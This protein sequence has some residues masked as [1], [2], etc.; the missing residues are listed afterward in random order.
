[1]IASACIAGPFHPSAFGITDPL[2][3]ACVA[4]EIVGLL[5]EQ[6]Q[7]AAMENARAKLDG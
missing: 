3:V 6:S 2:D 5:H 4:E 7:K 1:M